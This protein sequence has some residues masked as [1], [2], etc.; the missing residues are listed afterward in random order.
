NDVRLW[1]AARIT[2]PSNAARTTMT[3]AETTT[4]SGNDCATKIKPVIANAASWRR[5]S[6][7]NTLRTHR[8]FSERLLL[9]S[10]FAAIV[11]KVRSVTIRNPRAS[12]KKYMALAAS[13]LQYLAIRANNRNE[14]AADA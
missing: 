11:V 2:S 1:S 7:P 10:R 9:L 6:S 3:E 13:T 8:T 12:V 14:H 4:D 5:R